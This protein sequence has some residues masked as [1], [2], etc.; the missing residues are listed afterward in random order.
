MG[1][2]EL[3][4]VMRVMLSFFDEVDIVVDDGT[5]E[6]GGDDVVIVM[7][8]SFSI[9]ELFIFSDWP[10]GRSGTK[11]IQI[12]GALVVRMLVLYIV[13]YRRR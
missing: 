4:P 5:R 8:S 3:A 1:I 7:T 9:L 2:D 10:S 11:G 6:A 12:S 13:R